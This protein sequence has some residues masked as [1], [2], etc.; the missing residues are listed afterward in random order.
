MTV[1]KQL[2]K[3][4]STV[5]YAWHRDKSNKFTVDTHFETNGSKLFYLLNGQM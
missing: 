2:A 1:Q 3:L 5:A 4:D